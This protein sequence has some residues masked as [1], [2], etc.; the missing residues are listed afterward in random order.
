MRYITLLPTEEITLKEGYKNHPKHYFRQKCYALLLNNDGMSVPKIAK[1]L[2]IRTRTIYKLMN[3]WQNQG[4]SSL[5]I[6]SGRGR[7]PKLSVKNEEL[8]KL[9]KKKP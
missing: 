7:K 6:R 5:P 9:V 2:N 8:V 1:L 4:I 3:T